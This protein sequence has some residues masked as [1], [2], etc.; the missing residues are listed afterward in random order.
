MSKDAKKPQTVGELISSTYFNDAQETMKKFSEQREKILATLRPTVE[1]IAEISRSL[2]LPKTDH[3]VLKNYQPTDVLILKELRQL[4][5]KKEKTLQTQ[6]DDFVIVY[7][8]NDVSLNRVIDGKVYSYDLSENGKRKRLLELLLD[9][10]GYV[11]TEELKNLLDCPTTQA[12]AKIKQTFNDYA[13]NT[14]KLKK[15]EIINSKKGSG[16]RINP[17]IHI[18]K[19]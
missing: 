18:E 8:T 14:L 1:R 3:Y 12:V 15:I 10:K 9:R 6:G 4:N 5:A 7:D 2:T 16:Y 13:C 19:E 17:K 11:K